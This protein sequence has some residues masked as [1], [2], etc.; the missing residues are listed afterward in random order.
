[1][2]SL[3]WQPASTEA[4]REHLLLI[5]V[6]AGMA[7]FGLTSGCNR[8]TPS[9]QERSAQASGIETPAVKIVKPEKKNVR[10]LIERP[11]CN[12]AAFERTPLYAKVPGYVVTWN[13][14]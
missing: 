8:P 6:S 14:D 12:I 4:R 2:R 11:G 3:Y 9:P 1:M 7:L 5:A 10:R 13:F